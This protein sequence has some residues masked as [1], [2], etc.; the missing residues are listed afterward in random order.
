MNAKIICLFLFFGIFLFSGC[1]QQNPAG[2]SPDKVFS[3]EEV[4]QHNTASDCWAAID[5][6]VYNLTDFLPDSPLG[7]SLVQGCGKEIANLFGN[8][9]FQGKM[10]DANS[11]QRTD[12][13]RMNRDFNGFRP[14]GNTLPVDGNSLRQNP[15]RQRQ[16]A[17][18][19]DFPLQFYLGKVKS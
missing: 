5:G 14:D 12:V 1:T 10:P 16:A 2:S 17:G 9:P 6:N 18:R 13:N 7:S 3:L 8:R 11:M 15:N 19:G 4:A